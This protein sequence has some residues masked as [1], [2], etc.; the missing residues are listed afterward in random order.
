[1]CK[2][3]ALNPQQQLANSRYL[4]DEKGSQTEN[5]GVMVFD[6]T[7]AKIKPTKKALKRQK[8]AHKKL[9]KL[10]KQQKKWVKKQ[11]KLERSFHKLQKHFPVY[12]ET[13]NTP[14]H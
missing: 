14:I 12:M 6:P 13:E 11:K 8:K 2:P 10:A 4:D 7:G 5:G 3:I 9:A 1:M